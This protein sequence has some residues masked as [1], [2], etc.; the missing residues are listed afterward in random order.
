MNGDYLLYVVIGLLAGY[1][2]GWQGDFTAIV[3]VSLFYLSIWLF[4]IKEEKGGKNE[5]RNRKK[6]K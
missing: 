5:G 4:I 1:F 2:F 6:A 3:M